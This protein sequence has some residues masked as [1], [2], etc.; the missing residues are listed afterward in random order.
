MVEMITTY[1]LVII[2][3]YF[4]WN[5][6][7]ACRLIW[8]HGELDSTSRNEW[9]GFCR[10]WKW[11]DSCKVNK[12]EKICKRKTIKRTRLEAM[13]FHI[14]RFSVFF[15]FFSFSSLS[16]NNFSVFLCMFYVMFREELNPLHDIISSFES[17]FYTIF[18][19]FSMSF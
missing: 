3:F 19:L 13:K 4:Y 15:I 5:V 17:F 16:H 6:L 11:N 8:Y 9:N 14:F 7:V 1:V 10:I 2:Q 18:P 12:I